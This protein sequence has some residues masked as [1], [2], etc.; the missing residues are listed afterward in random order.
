MG[1]AE[2]VKKDR[3]STYVAKA[4]HLKCSQTLTNHKIKNTLMF[5]VKFAIQTSYLYCMTRNGYSEMKCAKRVCIEMECFVIH[6]RSASICF[7]R[8]AIF[9]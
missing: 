3:N 8:N 6:V 4:K 9:K 5:R 7:L 2:Y 1:T